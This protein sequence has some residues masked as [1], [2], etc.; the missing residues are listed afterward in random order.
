M[1]PTLDA[2]H[3]EMGLIPG[4]PFTPVPGTTRVYV[5]WVYGAVGS[6][7]G[8]VLT[9]DMAYKVAGLPGYTST[10]ESALERI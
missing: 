6:R 8:I 4:A 9:S 2:W 7:D 10:L 5:T 1:T 3:T